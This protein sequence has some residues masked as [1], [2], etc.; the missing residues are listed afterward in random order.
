MTVKAPLSV[1]LN[2]PVDEDQAEVQQVFP[3][4]LS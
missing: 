2:A 4:D 3:K 1:K